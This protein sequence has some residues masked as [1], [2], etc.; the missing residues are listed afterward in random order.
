[1][2]PQSRCDGSIPI[3]LI[4]V[5]IRLSRLGDGLVIDYE[6]D[7]VRKIATEIC[8]DN[9]IGLLGALNEL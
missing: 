5:L 2:I 7:A 3:A 9:I 6:V 8:F 1:M 4:R